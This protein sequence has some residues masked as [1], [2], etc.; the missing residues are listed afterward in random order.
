MA[1]TLLFSDLE[2]HWAGSCIN[3]LAQRNLIRG[4]PD[5]T[6]RPNAL[7]NRAEFAALLLNLFPDILPLRKTLDFSDV[8]TTY[9]AYKVIQKVTESGFLS[10]YPDR[11]FKP[12][13]PL[14]RL[15]IFLALANGLKCPIPP[16]PAQIVKQYF[17]DFTQIPDYAAPAIAGAA[18]AK[19]IVN[20][21]NVRQLNPNQNAT[22]GEVVAA[23]YQTLSKAWQ[24]SPISPYIVGNPLSFPS[25]DSFQDAVGSIGAEVKDFALTITRQNQIVYHQNLPKAEQN[26]YDPAVSVRIIDLDKGGEPEIIVTGRDRTNNNFITWIY[27]YQTLTKKYTNKEYQWGDIGYQLQDLNQDKIWKFITY[28]RT[29]DIFSQNPLDS[30]L[31]IQ[32]W[33]WKKGDLINITENQPEALRV[34][35][36]QLWTEQINR[37]RRNQDVKALLAAYLADKYLIGQKRD[38]WLQI[39]QLYQGSDATF[40]FD[41]IF[42]TLATNNYLSIEFL[43]TAEFEQIEPFFEGLAQVKNNG[44]WG[45]LDDKGKTVILPQFIGVEVFSEGKTCVRKNNQYGLINRQGNFHISAK[46]DTIVHFEDDLLPVEIWGKWGYIDPLEKMIIPVQFDGADKFC[47]GLALV[48]NGDKYGYIDITG[49]TIIPLQFEGGDRV[50]QGLAR[51]WVRDKIGFIDKAGNFVIP[52]QFD[53]ADPFRDGITRVCQGNKWGYLSLPASPLPIGAGFKLEFDYVDTIYF[54]WGRVRQGNLWGYVDI[55]GKIAIVPQFDAVDNFEG[56][57]ARVKKGTLYGIIN[58]TGKLVVPGTFNNVGNLVD[59]IAWVK[60]QQKYG[61]VDGMG[62]VIILPQFDEAYPFQQNLARV[63]LNNKYGYIDRKG[64]SAIDP[65]F[66]NAKDFTEGLAPVQINNQWGYIHQTGKMII[67]P[68]FDW[69]DNFIKNNARVL[70]NGKWGYLLHPLQ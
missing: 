34:H 55:N 49:K 3:Q 32:I 15:Q 17:A 50:S 70:K 61:Y 16:N 13:A 18:E 68:Q 23:L 37:Q 21:P 60:I 35:A 67:S 6:F 56:N 44:K 69:A 64:K 12:T 40:Y 31:P 2:N 46:Y 38:G 39:R 14:S 22:R 66:D 20:Y 7:V 19:L 47:E 43:G 9:W 59:N 11:T 52:P 54:G 57:F 27:Q 48:W 45:Y 28:Q 65:Q 8:P 51:V 5:R 26:K 30:A 58:K 41:K 24:I 4:Y 36:N 33:Q 10:G 25:Q 53:Y 63:K 42:D 29:F 1:N 62:T